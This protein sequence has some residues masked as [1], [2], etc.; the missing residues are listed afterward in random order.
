MSTYSNCLD[1]IKALKIKSEYDSYF[2][3]IRDYIEKIWFPLSCSTNYRQSYSYR[4]LIYL[5]SCYENYQPEL[6]LI[7]WRN[8]VECVRFYNSLNKT[9]N[10]KSDK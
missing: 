5:G 1:H 10:E 6:R 8:F 9:Q 7:F 4:L 3:S 2:N